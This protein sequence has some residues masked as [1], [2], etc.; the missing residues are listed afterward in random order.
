VVAGITDRR[1]IRSILTAVR[2]APAPPARAPGRP[3]PQ[4]PE[5]C[6]E[7][8]I[9]RVLGDQRFC[10]EALYR[11]AEGYLHPIGRHHAMLFE[12]LLGITRQNYEVLK[13][14]LLRAATSVEVDAGKPSPFPASCGFLD[15]AA[16]P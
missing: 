2:L 11:R 4:R 15:A 5:T 13:A 16:P 7:A 9:L 3:P 6:F 10:V 1:L 8:P 14:Q 12:T